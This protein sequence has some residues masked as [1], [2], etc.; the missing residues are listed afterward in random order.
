MAGTSDDPTTGE[1]RLPSERAVVLVPVKSF[2]AAKGR[3]AG[4]LD[5]PTRA[6]LAR[7]MAEVVVAAAAPLPVVVVC[8]DRDVAS[9]AQAVGATVLWT[10]GLGL[11]GAVDE[12]VRR[13][14][15]AGVRRVV[16][17]HADLPFAT[18]LSA[19]ADVDG[20]AVALVPDR[21]HDGTN[22]ASV[23]T[24]RGFG[25]RY[26]A[27]S[28]AA[29]RAEAERLGLPVRVVE[30]EVLGWDVD[31]PDDLRPPEHLGRVPLGGTA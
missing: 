16:V 31:E 7:S 22:V 11:N 30:S 27:G 20:D 3:L 13:L 28:L 5:A 8:D 6:A 4:V 25:F 26:G 9:W 1:P 10:E 24:G 2:A 17:A 29:H 21:R 23:P 12:G 15:G 14:A 19:L 18:G